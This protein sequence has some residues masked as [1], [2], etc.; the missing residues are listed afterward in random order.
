[1]KKKKPCR[2]CGGNGR[3]GSQRIEGLTC[4]CSSCNGTG[5]EK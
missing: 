5:K 3:L 1:M 2:V 4:R